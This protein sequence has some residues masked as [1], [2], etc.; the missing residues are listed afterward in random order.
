MLGSCFFDFFCSGSVKL[1]AIFVLPDKSGCAAIGIAFEEFDRPQS[2][3]WWVDENVSNTGI[4]MRSAE[5][6][7]ERDYSVGPVISVTGAAI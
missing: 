1:H 3:L 5:G 4:K 6:G 2:R 7:D